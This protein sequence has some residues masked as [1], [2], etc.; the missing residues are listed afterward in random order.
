MWCWWE[1]CGAQQKLCWELWVLERGCG[2]VD[3]F[4]VLYPEVPFFTCALPHVSASRVDRAYV[5]EGWAERLGR[6]THIPRLSDH[7]ALVVDMEGG[8]GRFVLPGVQAGRGSGRS[9]FWKL[10]CV[11][12]RDEDFVVEMEELVERWRGRKEKFTNLSDW[13]DLGIKLAVGV[14]CWA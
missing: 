2:L 6:V 14:L 12:L 11:V 10:N 4:W 3:C 13:W 7:S 5:L 8:E 1:G 9:R